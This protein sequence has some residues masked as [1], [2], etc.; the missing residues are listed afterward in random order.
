MTRTNGEKHR[1][2]LVEDHPVTRDG[3]AGII[4]FQSDL[5]VCGQSATA[6]AALKEIPKAKADLVIVDI[7]LADGSGLD[8]IKD[9]AAMHPGLPTLVLSTH[10]EKVYAERSLRAGA[11]GYVMKQEP[12]ERV[13]KCMR[14]ILRGEICVSEAMRSRLL[15]R[16]HGHRDATAGVDQLSDRELEVFRMLGEGHGTAEIAQRL[17][18]SVS[19][20]ET[21]RAHIKDKLG[22]ANGMDLVTTAVRW[23][24]TQ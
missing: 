5:V 13:L 15:G 23:V 18:I 16:L 3:L 12:T 21:Y 24:Q 17:H 11:H 10:D 2:F 19:T 9:L 14:G 4:N 7:T 1:V 22:L 6:V 8:L 20:V